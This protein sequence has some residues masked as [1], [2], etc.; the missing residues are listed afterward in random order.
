MPIDASDLELRPS[1]ATP[2]FEQLY[3]QIRAKLLSGEWEPDTK[4]PTEADLAIALGLSRG[5][6]TRAYSML[7]ADGLVVWSKGKGIFSSDDETLA[8]IRQEE[9]NRGQRRA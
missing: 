8:E 9:Q 4:L 3:L 7:K 6:S 1:G 2:L 5:T